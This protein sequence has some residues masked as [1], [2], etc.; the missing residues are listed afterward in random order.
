MNKHK[1]IT[2]TEMCHEENFNKGNLIFVLY[3]KYNN[4]KYIK[5]IIQEVKY[6]IKLNVI[7]LTNEAYKSVGLL[8][9][10]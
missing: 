2:Q 7:D 10:Y 9:L 5:D 6:V 4:F 1:H 3:I 8:V